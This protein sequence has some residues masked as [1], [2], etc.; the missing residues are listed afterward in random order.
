M[1]ESELLVASGQAPTKVSYD[2]EKINPCLQEQFLCGNLYFPVSDEQHWPILDL[3]LSHTNF[4]HQLFSSTQANKNCHIENCHIK[5]AAVDGF[6]KE[7]FFQS[8]LEFMN[9]S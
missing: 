2:T 6:L 1:M 9:N 8:F 5:M 4:L 7:R 3:Q